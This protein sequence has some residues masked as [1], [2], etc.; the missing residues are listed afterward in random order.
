MKSFAIA[1]ALPAPGSS[2]ACSLR[3]GT[4]LGRIGLAVHHRH[5]QT[6]VLGAISVETAGTPGNPHANADQPHHP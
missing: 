6:R 3:H 2:A 5:L 4:A 1:L